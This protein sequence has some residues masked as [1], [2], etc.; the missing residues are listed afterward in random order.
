M[1]EIDEGERSDALRLLGMLDRRADL[2][3]EL[4]EQAKMKILNAPCTSDEIW[5]SYGWELKNYQ[6]REEEHRRVW[7]IISA[8]LEDA[9][10]SRERGAGSGSKYLWKSV[11]VP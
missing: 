1:G 10:F 6:P 8:D 2:A 7:K 11:I 4:L 5:A 3:R 9:G